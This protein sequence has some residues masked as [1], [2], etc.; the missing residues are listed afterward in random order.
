[1]AKIVSQTRLD[2]GLEMILVGIELVTVF[3]HKQE[4]IETTK[5]QPILEVFACAYLALQ[6]LIILVKLATIMGVTR[7]NRHCLQTLS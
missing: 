6:G 3:G 7:T 5:A 2:L 4:W 1:L